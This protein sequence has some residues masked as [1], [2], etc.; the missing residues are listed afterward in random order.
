MQPSK[1]NLSLLCGAL[2]FCLFACHSKGKDM[3]SS[4]DARI[5][6]RDSVYDFGILKPGDT[7][8]EHVF[9]FT[10]VGESPAVILNVTPACKCI[11]VEYSRDVIRQG[12]QGFVKVIYDGTA[13]S[14]GYFDKS[15]LVHIN[16]IKTYILRVR[17]SLELP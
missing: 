9:H 2:I 16:S 11:T 7:K 15:V 5:L 10:N 14:A 1:I 13:S 8:Q 12:D 17:G 6:F 3:K 4:Y